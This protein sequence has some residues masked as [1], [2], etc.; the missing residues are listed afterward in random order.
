MG[1]GERKERREACRR[2]DPSE[3]RASCR[4][5]AAEGG[6]RTRCRLLTCLRAEAEEPGG[7]LVDEVAWES[8]MPGRP[9][10][11]IGSTGFCPKWTVSH[12]RPTRLPIGL[13]IVGRAS[14][15]M[16]R[17]GPFPS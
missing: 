7:A 5:A 10:R 17:P 11:P 16:G 4:V 8:A 2:E 3:G 1:R 9:Y 12:L 6:R 15:P 14:D 13:A